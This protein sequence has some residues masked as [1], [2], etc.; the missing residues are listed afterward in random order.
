MTV[1]L[2][3]VGGSP[4]PVVHVLKTKRPEKVIFFT[5]RESRQQVE[6]QILPVIDYFPACGF[7]VVENA[8]DIGACTFELLREVPREMR[9]LGETVRWPSLCGYTGGTKAMSAAVVWATSRYPCSL[10][11]V[12]GG[13]RS[14]QGLGV[15]E[16]GSEYLINIENPWNRVGWYET[17]TVFELFNRA[18][19]YNAARLL[20]GLRE[21]VQ[22]SE[23]RLLIEWLVGW[24]HAMA[25]W[26][27]FQLQKARN[28]IEK[29]AREFGRILPLIQLHLPELE[30]LGDWLEAARDRMACLQ[31]GKKGELPLTAA[32]IEDLLANALRRARLEGKFED[33]VARLY[34]AF[35]KE[36]RRLLLEQGIDNSN[37]A[38]EQI[39]GPLKECYRVY[40]DAEGCC[41]FGLEASY[42]LLA[43]LDNPVGRRF[44][45]RHA[46]IMQ[47][48][49]KRNASILGHGTHPVQEAEFEQL[50]QIL[51]DFMECR[52]TDLFVFPR[53]EG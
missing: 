30:P 4:E 17:R 41:R 12:G 13:R 26:D 45:E 51:L 6:Q 16:S 29:A 46:E 32:L 42:R 18:Q 40:A 22:D 48:L 2:I 5:S 23:P 33:A 10:L 7:V 27:H 11:Y 47:C 36:A 28:G 25:D 20:D 44:M 8:E 31:V 15:V 19:Y 9:K 14:K 52:E 39:P 50:L 34:S 37:C 35:E 43:A 21:K 3:S 24:M 38:L 49:G 53:L 1:L